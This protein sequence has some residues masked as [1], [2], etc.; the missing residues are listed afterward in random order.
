L[1]LNQRTFSESVE[2][3]ELDPSPQTLIHS[4]IAWTSHRLNFR[5]ITSFVQVLIYKKMFHNFFNRI[6]GYRVPEIGQPTSVLHGISVKNE[7]GLLVG[8]PKSWKR[9]LDEQITRA[10]QTSNPAAADS[11]IKFFISYNGVIPDVTPSEASTEEKVDDKAHAVLEDTVT[12]EPE[13]AK[14][15]TPLVEDDDEETPTLR[16][17]VKPVSL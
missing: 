1:C 7:N 4:I 14:P 3:Q 2:I 17:T 12:K 6:S 11:A 10:E 16:Q 9:I 5:R 13:V 15:Q 8:L